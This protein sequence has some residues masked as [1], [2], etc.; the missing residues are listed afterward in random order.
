[1]ARSLASQRWPV[2]IRN[3]RNPAE[4]TDALRALKNEIVG[5]ALKKEIVVTMGLVEPVVRMSFNKSTSK[6]DSKAHDHT[7]ASRPLTE[8]E[9]VRLQGLQVL[10]SIAL[11]S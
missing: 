11:G 2:L 3:A 5:H 10:G 1:M 4:Q 6:Q 8:E 7:F 9:M